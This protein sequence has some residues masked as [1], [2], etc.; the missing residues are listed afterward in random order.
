M[1][2]PNRLA[3]RVAAVSLIALATACTGPVTGGQRNAALDGKAEAGKVGLAT[4]AQIALESNDI[5]TATA[6][7]E[8]AVEAS[9]NDASFR[10]LLGNCYL[11]AGRFQSAAAAYKDSLTLVGNQPKVA[12]RL[13]LVQTALGR[14]AE[15]NELLYQ[16]Q[17]I[18]DPTDLGLALALAGNSAAAI[19][20][21]E[22]ASR[23]VAAEPRTRQNLA[24]AYALAGR[25]NEARVVA[26]QDVPADQLDARIQQ[27]MALSKPA[28]QSDQVASFIGISPVVGDPG[29]PV[30]LA[31]NK[32]ADDVRYAAAEPVPTPAVTEGLTET[33]SVAVP[34]AAPYQPEPAPVMAETAPVADP[35]APQPDPAPVV[36]MA[37]A[38]RRA[39]VAEPALSPSAVRVTQAVS[40]LRRAAARANAR[41]GKV[42]VQ[43]GAYSS[44]DRIQ[45]AWKKVSNNYAAVKGYTPVS[46]RYSGPKGTFYRLSVQGFGSDREARK[47]CSSLQQSGRACFV[48]TTAGDAPFQFAAR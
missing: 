8:Q 1:T 15:A 46:A 13:A 31:L 38:P 26:S 19:Q 43:L 6:L 34:Q 4:R 22:Q 35:I 24:L 42:V 25:W 23:Q 30:R 27:W 33:A 5:A 48:R 18:M 14:N 28:H 7:A 9:P 29:Q 32:S 12:L 20:V 17:Q 44:R 21:L 10:A 16:A 3:A 41:D 39:P 40:N 36:A 11:A 45:A 37:E 2:K 47:F